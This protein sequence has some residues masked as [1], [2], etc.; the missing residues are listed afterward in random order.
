[1]AA[2]DDLNS[3]RI[4]L[5]GVISIIVTA[6]TA[7]AVN[8]L[9]YALVSYQQRE[10]AAESDYRRQRAILAE[11]EAEVSEYGIDPDTGNVV[12]PVTEAMRQIADQS[13]HSASTDDEV[14]SNET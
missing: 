2:Y 12:I 14:E 3:K 6:I 10:T 9:Y 5:V 11:Q 8:V 7:L 4:L 13:N 1:M